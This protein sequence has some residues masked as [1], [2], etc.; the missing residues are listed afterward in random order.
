[1]THHYPPKWKPVARATFALKCLPPWR[2]VTLE[3]CQCRAPAFAARLGWLVLP[4]KDEIV[5]SRSARAAIER[6]MAALGYKRMGVWRK[7][8]KTV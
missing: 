2:H 7:T 4:L 5:S 6:M 3:Q 1:M 8:G